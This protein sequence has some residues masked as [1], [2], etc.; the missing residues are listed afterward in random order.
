MLLYNMLCFSC[1]PPNNYCRWQKTRFDLNLI[2]V[3]CCV[4]CFCTS[5]RSENRMLYVK[6]LHYKQLLN[7]LK[8]HWNFAKTTSKR[9]PNDLLATSKRPRIVFF[10]LLEAKMTE[11]VALAR[12]SNTFVA[13]KPSSSRR[14]EVFSDIERLPFHIF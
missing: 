9:P 5:V 12:F 14:F 11:G 10:S 1:F 3:A 4:T 7:L 6:I 8:S 13:L 2:F